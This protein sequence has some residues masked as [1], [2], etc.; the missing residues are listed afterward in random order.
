MAESWARLPGRT[1]TR[2]RRQAA[3]LLEVLVVIAIMGVLI[4]LL[5]P[6]IQKVRATTTRLQR[7]NQMKQIILAAHNFASRHDGCLPSASPA[8]PDFTS[9]FFADLFPYIEQSNL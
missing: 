6:A 9:L 7:V 3:S 1:W 2:C 8:P 4:G 5:L